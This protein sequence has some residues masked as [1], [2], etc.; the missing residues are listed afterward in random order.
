MGKK[1]DAATL[2]EIKTHYHFA[3]KAR[4]RIFAT[5]TALGDFL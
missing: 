5:N 2:P 4:L 3:G 1:E